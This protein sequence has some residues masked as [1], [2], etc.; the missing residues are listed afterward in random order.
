M[1]F[2]FPSSAAHF[3]KIGL[4]IQKKQ[5]LALF[6]VWLIVCGPV[7]S[8]TAGSSQGSAVPQINS[9]G[10]LM[11]RTF[12]SPEV[13][14]PN[15]RNSQRTYDLIRAGNLYLSLQDAIALALE[16]NLD[17]QLQRYSSAIAATDTLRARGGGLLRGLTY[18]VNELP[19]GVGGPGSPL[20]TTVG[21]AAPATQVNANS[22][23]FA[24][25]T[26]AQN[27]LSVQS[28][29][30]VATGPA[31][32]I[33]DPAITGSFSY[34]HLSQLQTTL[35]S[36]GVSNLVSDNETGSAGYQQGF[37]SGANVNLNY[38]STRTDF[39]S[40]RSDYN[41]Y[42]V[43]ALA[44]T[45]DQP[46]LR[47]FGI[48]L[49]RRFIHIAENQERIAQLVFSQQLIDTV[50]SIIRLYWDLVS[51]N[52]DVR[53]KQE[54]L[55][56]AQKLL[57][58]N[59]AQVEVGTLAPLQLTQAAAEVARSKEDLINSSN[60]VAQQELILKNSITRSGAD[61]TTLD[62][63][64]IVPL[65][66]ITVPPQESLPSAG[67]LM[68]E[69]LRN[70]PDLA[71]AQLQIGNASLALKGSRNEVRPQLDLVG[72][73]TNNAFAG[74][75]N[76]LPAVASA[77]PRAPDPSLLGNS[78]TILSQLVDRNYPNYTLGFQLTIPIR[79]RVAQADVARDELQLRQSQV[80]LRQTVNQVRLEVQNAL[81]AVM[82][83][84]ATYDASAET[85]R[86]QEEALSAEQQRFAVGQSTSF[87]IIQ[88]Q[89]D[90][91][92][93]RST[94]V[95]AEDDYAKARAALDRA[96]GQT[97]A[98]NNVS[99][100]EALSGTV[101]RPPSSIPPNPK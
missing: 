72:S 82:R 96:T 41:P 83:A 69:A 52:N 13:S 35:L 26:E 36:N 51:L 94:E 10:R 78:G 8:Q 77:T 11:F 43:G 54:A 61:D 29:I 33:F 5:I 74:T 38:T 93:A 3:L 86:L 22:A 39:N 99:F 30:P 55:G 48:D 90:L 56:A 47:G 27:N 67:E 45:V 64:H 34:Q 75:I 42:T 46:L 21:G 50:A 59:R 100:A 19:Q 14:A 20:L 49:N 7:F 24:V 15:F 57:E 88:F 76:S 1:A 40:F 89:R 92:Q 62:T 2:E 25:I 84:R 80:R 63:V 44:L 87:Q 85:T 31:V 79:N 18:T 97:L 60:L 66:S 16:N 4:P 98:A 9:P 71:Q 65:D 17:I 12:R 28:T 37:S 58:D 101:S 53:V 23:D 70:R 95:V 6:P 81:L 68:A 91:A 32:P 73:V